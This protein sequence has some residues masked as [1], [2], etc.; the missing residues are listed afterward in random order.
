M[1][2]EREALSSL[3]FKFLIHKTCSLKWIISKISSILKLCDAILPMVFTFDTSYKMEV[4]FVS[5][6]T[7]MSYKWCLTFFF[8]LTHSQERYS[9]E[10]IFNLDQGGQFYYSTKVGWQLLCSF[11]SRYASLISWQCKWWHVYKTTSIKP[12]YHQLN[13]N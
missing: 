7:V 3:N 8:F 9:T 4:F 1:S 6:L 10:E 11:Y 13:P 12:P 5:S 2:P